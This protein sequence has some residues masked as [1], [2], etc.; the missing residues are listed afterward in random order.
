VS[1]LISN[2]PKKGETW[3]VIIVGSGP[4]AFT[5]G[6]YTTRGALS[7]LI[8]AGEKWGGQLMNTS[9]VDN[10]PGFP[11]GV[12]GPELMFNMRKQ[13]E[14]FGAKIE[15]RNV[16]DVD[17]SKKPFRVFT[18]KEEY[19][20]KTVIIATGALTKWLGVKGEERLIGRGVSTCAPCD[21]PFFKDK[22]VAVVGGGDSAMEEAHVLTKYAKEVIL[23][24][25]RH[26][27]KASEAMQKKVFANPKI[28]ILWDS[29]VIEIIGD[30]SVNGIRVKNVKNQ[31]EETI[32]LD[33]IFVAVGHKPDSD[34][35]VNKVEMDE[36]GYILP[37]GFHCGTS[38]KGV[39]VA[40]DVLDKDFKQAVVA[41]GSGC[42]AAMEA[43][44]Y[45][46]KV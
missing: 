15:N 4:A 3:D 8:L 20:S 25:R 40:G 19:F 16:T 14:R 11:E 33:G 24:H 46:D 34:V 12:L 29:E 43:I 2:L 39:F 6:I 42:I 32:E 18:G 31:K 13:T 10:F 35:F 7:T 5:A 37:E 28:R 45:L 27:F 23:I 41:S 26:E 36:K 30:K 44:K 1:D 21:A 38:V 9:M 22:K 17:F